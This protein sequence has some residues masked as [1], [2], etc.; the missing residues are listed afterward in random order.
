MLEEAV[1]IIQMKNEQVREP[2]RRRANVPSLMLPTASQQESDNPAESMEPA[3]RT[4]IDTIKTYANEI[5]SLLKSE[6]LETSFV[7]K[8]TKSP[9]EM[10]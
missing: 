4:D 7:R 2:E 8:S 9:I 5:F 6:D 1:E 3:I 10:L